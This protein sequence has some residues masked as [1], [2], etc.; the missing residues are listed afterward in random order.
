VTTTLQTLS[1]HDALPIFERQRRNEEKQENRRVPQL[2]LGFALER[3]LPG[4]EGI[5]PLADLVRLVVL[6]ASRKGDLLQQ[7]LIHLR[8]LL[9]SEEHTS[10]LQSPDHLVY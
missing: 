8:L 1:I 10:E 6:P 2:D 7:S 5:H 3:D 4:L 9:R